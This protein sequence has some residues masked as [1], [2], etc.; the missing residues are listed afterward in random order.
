VHKLVWLLVL[1]GCGPSSYS[2]FR[3]QLTGRWCDR[4]VRCGEVGVSERG[5]CGVPAPLALSMVGRVDVAAE[6]AAGRMQF[7]S[8]GAQYCLDAVAG[9]PCGPAQAAYAFLLHCH[10]VVGPNVDNGGTCYGSEEC[11]GGACVQNAAGCAGTCSGYAPPGAPCV[12][13]GGTPGQT[14]DPTVHYCAGTCQHKKHGG[15]ACAADVECAFD[16]ACVGGKCG[17]PARAGQGQPCG[18]AQPTCADGLYCSSAGKCA[19]RPGRGAACD[20]QD[21]CSDG[22]VCIGGAC[23]P[24][25]S[26]GGACGGAGCPATESCMGGTCVAASGPVGIRQSCKSDGDCAAGLWCQND[27]CQWQ[28]GIGGSCVQSAACAAGLQ[29]D[30]M[31]LRCRASLSCSMPQP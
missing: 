6:I 4:Q 27:I 28:A 7:S 26:A 1:A 10:A 17:D 31:A 18:D 20:T 19:P 14:C 12:P 13:A 24:W 8:D 11:V 21:A 3:A 9:A 23:A 30:P 29:C 15:D 2:D 16:L 5:R 22:L 25:L